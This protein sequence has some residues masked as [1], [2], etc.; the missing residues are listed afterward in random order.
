[1]IESCA[2]WKWADND[3]TKKPMT[4]IQEKAATALH[5]SSVICFLFAS[6]EVLLLI[7]WSI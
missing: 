7:V 5:Q 2:E 1:M 3:T 6:G 4:E